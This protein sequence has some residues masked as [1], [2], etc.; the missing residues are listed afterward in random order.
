MGGSGRNEGRENCGK[1][2]LYDSKNLFEY[3]WGA[4]VIIYN[5]RN[6]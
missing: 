4:K 2:A 3:K 6:E 5:S 1:D